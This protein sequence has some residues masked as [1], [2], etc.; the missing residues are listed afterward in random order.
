MLHFL[1][2]VYLLIAVE[3]HSLG[4]HPFEIACR[5]RKHKHWD[6][7][8]TRHSRRFS[9]INLIIFVTFW[10]VYLRKFFTGREISDDPP[11]GQLIACF[12]LLLA[13]WPLP[14]LFYVCR[15]ELSS[16]INYSRLNLDNKRK[17]KLT[18]QYFWLLTLQLNVTTD[19]TCTVMLVQQVYS[20]VQCAKRT[21][22]SIAV[23]IW[24][25]ITFMGRT[26]LNSRLNWHFSN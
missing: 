21:F 4:V 20:C 17:T 10:R 9:L 23:N 8:L 11:R 16:T 1:I 13:F 26:C 15:Y 25:C 18:Q 14:R 3:F 6:I 7:N 22:H 12:L 5:A 19:S 2:V 24:L